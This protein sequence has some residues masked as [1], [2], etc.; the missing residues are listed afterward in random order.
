MLGRLSNDL[1]YMLSNI[2]TSIITS[3]DILLAM[4]KNEDTICHFLL[5]DYGISYDDILSETDKYIVVKKEDGFT[6]KVNEILNLA[7]EYM[8]K[9]H[10]DYIYD[11]HLFL[12]ILNTDSIAKEILIDLGVDIDCAILDLMDI[13]NLDDDKNLDYTKSITKK[14]KDITFIGR[15]EYIKRLDLII[16]RKVKNNPLLIG[17]A[18]VGKT[19]IVEGLAKY[20]LDNNINYE[21]IS[22]DLGMAIA[23]AK[24]RGDFEERIMEVINKIENNSHIILF[25]DEIHNLV[26][27]GGSEGGVDAANL[28]K[29]VL[30]RN[31]IKCIGATT[32]DE[33]K[34]YIEKD[35][36]L[37]R[38]FENVYVY[39]PDKKEVIKI[40]Y[41]IKKD[42][43][44]YHNIIINDEIIEYIYETSKNIPNRRFPDKAIDILDEVCAYAKINNKDVTTDIVDEVLIDIIG[45]NRYIKCKYDF[46]K[47]YVAKRY[48]GLN[49]ICLVKILFNGNEEGLNELKDSVL[50]AFNMNNEVVL[51]IDLANYTD[52]MQISSLVGSAPGY[53]GYYDGGLLN[54]IKN[55]HNHY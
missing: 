24:Y 16:N 22:L 51:D 48:F 14:A 35:K 8:I 10:S 17:E 23:G 33:Y 19:A 11:E 50:E 15:E 55:I 38:R 32:I 30:S 4:Y 49:D 27:I 37:A 12:A 41:G 9:Y 45:I 29:P 18:G 6:K 21:I 13:F 44:I 31:N 40:L 26:G 53:V 25:I 7:N 3:A 34:R 39:E 5:N 54:H 36:A 20:Y 43:E 47:K 42:F 46:L 52:N 1:G 28:L 2:N